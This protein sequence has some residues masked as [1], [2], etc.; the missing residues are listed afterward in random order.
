MSRISG[1]ASNP[2]AWYVATA[3]TLAL[4]VATIALD[5]PS[6]RSAAAPASVIARP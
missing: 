1:R 6:F 4:G 5:A 3:P 2:A